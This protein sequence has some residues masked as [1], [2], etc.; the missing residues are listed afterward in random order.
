MSIK[1]EIHTIKNSQGTGED[2]HY[3]HIFEG[4]PLSDN[5]LESNIQDSCS[6]TKSDVRATLSALHEHIINELSK[7][8]RVHIPSIGYFSLS[9]DLNS[10]DGKPVEKARADYI[11]VRNINF[12]PEASVLQHVRS[13]ARFER[14]NFTTKSR[15][16]TE[17]ALWNGVKTFLSTHH[18][19]NR[20]DME[21]QFGLRQNAALKWLRHFTETG[22]LKKE[23]ARNS[24]VY[25]L[26][27]QKG[28]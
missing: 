24:P 25:Y 12:R 28:K 4:R 23:G 3:A 6:L 18:C 14:A 26:S 11:S 5:E 21:L 8:N 7:G 22:V 20:R 2:R 1:Y 17:T 13:H 10:P 19:I 27:I 15:Q 9:V 16:H